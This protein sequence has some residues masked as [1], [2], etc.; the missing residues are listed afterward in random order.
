MI[1]AS[2]NKGKIKE[3]QVIL[4]DYEI[5]TLNDSNIEIDVVE[6]CDTFEGN[7]IK[8]AKEIYEIAQKAVIADDSGLC[9][10]EL[11]NWP[12]VYS[13]RFLGEEA[14]T[15]DK[16]TNLIERANETSTREAFINCTLVYY[17]GVE[18]IVE[19]SIIEGR[20]AREKIGDNG[21]GF[22]EVF[23]LEDGRT[24]AQLTIEEKN[25]IS[26][27]NKAAIKLNNTLKNRFK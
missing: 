10:K 3:I 21:F 5:K 19:S 17:D 9:I 16:N 12:G 25:E 14:S 1:F 20:I 11:N 23:E 24:L 8:K 13:D 26:A 6:D 7:A 22:D 27:R 18:L 4:K 15:S 2:N